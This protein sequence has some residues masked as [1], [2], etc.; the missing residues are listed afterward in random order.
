MV[1]KEL[2]EKVIRE[3]V[4]QVLLIA[5]ACLPGSQF[6]A[7]RKLTLDQF[8]RSGLGK[9]LDRIFQDYRNLE[10]QGMGRNRLC[11]RRSEP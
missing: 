4:G 10:W 9:D 8:G 1:T 7:F 11:E 6:E 2:V 5:Q 3:R